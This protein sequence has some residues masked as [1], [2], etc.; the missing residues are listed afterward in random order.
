M[1]L[2]LEADDMIRRFVLPKWGTPEEEPCQEC[3]AIS[4]RVAVL[5]SKTRDERRIALCGRHFLQLLQEFPDASE[6][7]EWPS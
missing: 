3:G 2:R 6:I 5:G 4:Y 7:R 1:P